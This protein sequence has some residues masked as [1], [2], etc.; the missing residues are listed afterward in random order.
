[1]LMFTL[2]HL[3]PFAGPFRDER[4]DLV[5]V[6]LT[7]PKPAVIPHVALQSSPPAA[8]LLHRRARKHPVPAPKP[9]SMRKPEI[10]LA[11]S[12]SKAASSPLPAQPQVRASA[13]TVRTTGINASG[14]GKN[15]GGDVPFSVRDQPVP[16]NRV[17]HPP[18]LLL[19]ALPIYPTEARLRGI[20][21]RVL[22]RAIIDRTGAIED[23]ISVVESVAIL[24]AAAIEALR[25]WRFKPGSDR[26]GHPLRVL[27][28]V[29]LHFSLH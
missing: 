28:E 17:A 11:P 26:D 24:D 8:P 15:A 22:L 10:A 5:Y 21:G 12:P 20:Q 3:R 18:V 27:V 16:I 2:R 14:D 9:H 23:D 25:K 13:A 1:V 19:R 29:P 7:Q 4:R 6:Y